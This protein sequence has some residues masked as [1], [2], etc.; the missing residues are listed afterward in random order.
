MGKVV[1]IK[2]VNHHLKFTVSLILKAMKLRKLDVKD[3]KR[4]GGVRGQG[5]NQVP[6]VRNH[7]LESANPIRS[8]KVD[9]YSD[10][11]GINDSVSHGISFSN[12]NYDITCAYPTTCQNNQ[13]T[14]G[15][16]KTPNMFKNEIWYILQTIN[17]RVQFSV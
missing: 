3:L 5:Q 15:Q 2:V 13:L 16:T 10:N 1:A 9:I 14:I 6:E 12:I 11:F 17:I 7:H 4:R 8:Q